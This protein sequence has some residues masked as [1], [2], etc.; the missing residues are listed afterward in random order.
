MRLKTKY[1]KIIDNFDFQCI[2]K[3]YFFKETYYKYI[4]NSQFLTIRTI[5]IYFVVVYNV[6]LRQTLLRFNETRLLSLI[7]K[8]RPLKRQR[9]ESMADYPIRCVDQTIIII[10]LLKIVCL[11]F[12]KNIQLLIYNASQSLMV[13]SQ[14]FFKILGNTIHM[15]FSVYSLEFL[16]KKAKNSYFKKCNYSNKANK[17]LAMR[18][19]ISLNMKWLFILKIKIKSTP[20]SN[21]V[22]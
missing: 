19:Y 7:T 16:S 17:L 1:L 20:V 14:F 4:E 6:F 2:Q 11:Q 22:L 8:A 21:S 10:W 13:I 9:F 15:G 18:Y 5:K 3:H 12:S